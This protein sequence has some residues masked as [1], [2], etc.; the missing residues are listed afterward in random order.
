MKFRFSWA[1]NKQ[2]ASPVSDVIFLEFFVE[3]YAVELHAWL[4]R[5]SHA[6]PL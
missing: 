2:N 4:V 5:R 3:F 6:T 1:E